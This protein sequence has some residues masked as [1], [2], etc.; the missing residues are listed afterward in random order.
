MWHLELN[1]ELFAGL[2]LRLN[3]RERLGSRELVVER[4]ERSAAGP[5]L[6]L[7]AKGESR[8]REL[9]LTLR[10]GF[11]RDGELLLSWSKRRASATL[12]D[13]DSL[14]GN[15][16][17][18]LVLEAQDSLQPHDVPSRVLLWGHVRLPWRLDVAPA[19]EWRRGFP[20]TLFEA[21]WT[22]A[23]R[24][25]RGGRLPSFFSLD[26]QV[27]RE[28]TLLGRPWRVGF[29]TYNLTR[30]FNP[31]DVQV[32]RASSRFRELSNSVGLSV[33]LT[34]KVSF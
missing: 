6:R 14:Y 24:R 5:E 32:N 12:N 31:R 25:N 19:F 8:I 15:L 1:Q 28:V 3:Y 20:Y 9:D 30:H 2:T 34:M 10:R 4:V 26:L 33:G 18:P 23:S 27:T 21:D 13:F 7:D 11:G 16:R 22:L 17:E 29:R